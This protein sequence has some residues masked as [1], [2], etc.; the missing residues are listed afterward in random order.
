MPGKPQSGGIHE[1]PNFHPALTNQV[2]REGESAVVQVRVTGKPT[3]K[4]G[5]FYLNE[6]TIN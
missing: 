1:P 4:I 5:L 6:Q 2:V 3:P